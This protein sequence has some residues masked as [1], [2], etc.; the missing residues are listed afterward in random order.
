MIA[1]GRDGMMVLEMLGGFVRMRCMDHEA[2]DERQLERA[3]DILL[4]GALLPGKRR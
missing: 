1:P 4:T 2:V 3:I